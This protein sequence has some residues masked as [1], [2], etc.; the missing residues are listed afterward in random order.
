[1]KKRIIFSL[2]YLILPSISFFIGILF[3][4]IFFVLGII[5]IYIIL[6]TELIFF[7]NIRPCNFL[8]LLFGI[9]MPSLVSFIYEYKTGRGFMQYIFS[10]T[11]TFLYTAP[12]S[13][14]SIIIFLVTFIKSKI[15][16]RTKKEH[17]A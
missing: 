5:I 4:S 3:M 13:I 1:M 10:F 17:H 15:K 11:L 16:N 9:L 14:S 8:F 7:F 2:L 6:I 12:F